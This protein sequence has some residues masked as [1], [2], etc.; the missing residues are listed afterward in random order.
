MRKS[1]LKKIGVNLLDILLIAIFIF[2]AFTL[3][4]RSSS[5]SINFN[6]LPS[7]ETVNEILIS[8]Y[9]RTPLS[10]EFDNSSLS[11]KFTSLKYSLLE[12]ASSNKFTAYFLN[13]FNKLG[14]GS[15]DC[16]SCAYPVSGCSDYETLIYY[17]PVD[18]S[19]KELHTKINNDQKLLIIDVRDEED[20]LKSHI[21]LSVNIP[22]L[23]IVNFMITVDRWSE[24]VVVGDNYIQTK[25]AAEALQRLNFHRVHRLNV[26][27]SEWDG[28]IESFVN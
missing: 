5:A 7:P 24:I 27:I 17:Y 10:P 13:Y 8:E 18:I 9:K 21:P 3:M 6:N 1:L 20:Y 25:L 4:S 26:P 19:L 12:F 23:D 28:E 15:S 22:L 14:F 11:A 2:V 16:S